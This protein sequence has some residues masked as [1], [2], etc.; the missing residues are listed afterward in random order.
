MSPLMEKKADDLFQLAN[1]ILCCPY[2]PLCLIPGGRLINHILPTSIPRQVSMM[3]NKKTAKA[4][5]AMVVNA[6]RLSS[7]F[8]SMLQKTVLS[9][10][11]SD[12]GN[13]RGMSS[14]GSSNPVCS[15]G[16][17]SGGDACPTCGP[18]VESSEL[19]PEGWPSWLW[20]KVE[21]QPWAA[22]KMLSDL[23]TIM[24]CRAQSILFRY[25]ANIGP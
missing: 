20:Y 6:I 4:A 19:T 23:V 9:N 21:A 2:A 13:S 7:L 3:S 15:C 22:H 8:T 18:V 14:T 12:G 1:D 10:A 5:A 17:S 24:A 11:S 16:T 25:A